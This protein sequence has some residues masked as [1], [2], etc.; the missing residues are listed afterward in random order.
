MGIEAGHEGFFFFFGPPGGGGDPHLNALLA[1]LGSR[2]RVG[3][4]RLQ[5]KSYNVP[6]SYKQMKPKFQ[7]RTSPGLV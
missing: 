3:I 2:I 5:E 6:L 7:T 4:E 1:H